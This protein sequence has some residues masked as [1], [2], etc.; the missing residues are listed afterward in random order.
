MSNQNSDLD[1]Q[2]NGKTDVLT[3]NLHKLCSDISKT[4]NRSKT[5]EKAFYI[6]KII[7]DCCDSSE[8]EVLH[9]QIAMNLDIKQV[10]KLENTLKGKS[11]SKQQPKQKKKRSEER[12]TLEKDIK[13]F[14]ESLQKK[15]KEKS[16]TVKPVKAYS[17][18]FPEDNDVV[19][20]TDCLNRLRD[21]K[22]IEDPQRHV[23]HKEQLERAKLNSQN[24]A[25]DK[26]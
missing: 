24:R 13:N 23:K 6:S 9:R 8:M 25:R 22:D 15:A 17:E 5:F 3:D 16:I 20:L 19:G 18:A 2:D 1:N 12:V 10:I 7:N 4:L 21:L 14:R 11:K 26:A